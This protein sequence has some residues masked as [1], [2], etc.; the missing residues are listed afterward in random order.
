MG[1]IV[2]FPFGAFSRVTSEELLGSITDES[3][4]G[5]LV[6]NIAP[7]FTRLTAG[8]FASPLA[9]N[10]TNNTTVGIYGLMDAVASGTETQ[11]NLHSRL[12]VASNQTSNAGIY[13]I[14]SHLRIDG[15]T[16]VTLSGGG[17][18][19]ALWA[20]YEA[21]GT[22]VADKWQ[23]AIDAAVEAG[24]AYTLN[25]V[26]YLAGVSVSTAVDTGATM[27]G[28]FYAILVKDASSGGGHLP[29]NVGIKMNS[30]VC[31]QAIDAIVTTPSASLENINTG[32]T[33]TSNSTYLTG[34]D[35][36][37]SSARGSSNLKLTGTF[38]GVNGGF[39]NI[40]SLVTN[41]AAHTGS[42]GGVIGIKSVVVNTA[43]MTD[44]S[45]YGAQFIA[46][47]NHASATMANE[48][49]LIGSESIA[50]ISDVGQAGT[51]IGANVVMRNYGT[52]AGSVNRGLQIVLDQ[53]GTKATEGTGI[54]VWNMAGTWDTVL[55]VSG[56]FSTFANFDDASTCFAAITNGPSTVAGQILVTM[57]NGNTGYIT[58]YS[59]TGT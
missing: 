31:D 11:R 25:G 41:S 19:A 4:T 17:V 3:G 14:Q 24:S 47:H 53:T 28:Y 18:N 20:Y 56:A 43:T 1:K 27:N 12:K 21:S 58:V 55:R 50:Y 7:N 30:G 59:T 45:I 40:Y 8:T 34:D 15:T 52:A 42:G 9:V 44:G 57:A 51:A 2:Q 29:F 33:L 6:F 32:L 26:N 16:P 37:Y 46:K 22:V 38:S 10:Q 48:A 13:S 35:I 54:C 49:A 39:S 36:T 23:F 5:V